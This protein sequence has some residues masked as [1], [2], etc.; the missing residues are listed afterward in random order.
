VGFVLRLSLAAADVAGGA[1]SQ[2]TGLG[3]ASVLDPNHEGSDTVASRIVTLFALAL[4]VAV[5]AHRTALA[6]LLE[7]FYALP[8]GTPIDPSQGAT[9][10]IEWVGE[11]IALGVRISMPVLA[12]TLVAQAILAFVA[13]TAPALQLYNLGVTIMVAAG[14]AAFLGTAPDTSSA[15]SADLDAMPGRIDRLLTEV[16]P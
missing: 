3:I 6:Y 10:L 5:G 14:F 7:S 12:I 16:R 13:R 1:L 2:A 15:L 11:A 4:A 8:I 9:V